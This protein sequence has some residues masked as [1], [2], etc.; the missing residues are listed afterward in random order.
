V[1]R[2]SGRILALLVAAFLVLFAVQ[3]ACSP[4]LR[5]ESERDLAESVGAASGMLAVDVMALRELLGAGLGRG[6][7]TARCA[8]FAQLRGQWGEGLAA[9]A[10]SGYGDQVSAAVR[11]AG[12]DASAA[13]AAFRQRPEA[14]YGERFLQVRERFAGRMTV[15]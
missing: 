13:W 7:L 15:R 6:E 12:G 10:L 3:R 4:F 8:E 1:A 5:I 14:V 11:E 2:G 9:V